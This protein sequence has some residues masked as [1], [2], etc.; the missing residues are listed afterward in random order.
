MDVAQG[1]DVL[2]LLLGRVG[3]L[4]S[5]ATEA[6]PFLGSWLNMVRA[7]GAS[8][9]M[10][11]GTARWARH[12]TRRR[13]SRRPARAGGFAPEE[14]AVDGDGER[15]EA[16]QAQIQIEGHPQGGILAAI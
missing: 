6:V 13:R 1:S 4:L 12:P 9:V 3:P 5:P 16:E 14:A 10:P 7:M 15:Q 2:E 11:R 8:V